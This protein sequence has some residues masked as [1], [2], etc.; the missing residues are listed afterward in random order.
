MVATQNPLE[1]HGALPLPERQ[2][3]RFLMRL[4]LGYAEP[5]REAPVLTEDPGLHAPPTLEK[6]LSPT[7]LIGLQKAADLVKLKESLLGYLLALIEA[8]RLHDGLALGAS[9]R[10]AFALCR[11]AQANAL[12]QGRDYCI[13]ENIRD[14]AIDVLA[15]RASV[16]ARGGL[17]PGRQASH[18]ALF[19][20]P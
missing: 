9:T 8:T 19:A 16:H 20:T 4:S 3:D 18:N 5:E 11:A 13:P 14:L 15:H 6:I 1:H 10:G 12:I 7:D 2:F 17:Q